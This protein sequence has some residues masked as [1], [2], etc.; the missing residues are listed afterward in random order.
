M[1]NT[2]RSGG[3][4]GL[5]S[6]RLK[7]ASPSEP[8][9]NDVDVSALKHR[10]AERGSVPTYNESDN[11]VPDD[12]VSFER[13]GYEVPKRAPKKEKSRFR[14]GKHSDDTKPAQSSADI[15][16]EFEDAAV[17]DET[18][19]TESLQSARRKERRDAA[20]ARTQKVVTVITIA[21]CLY[22]AF[23][24][25]GLAQTN[26]VYDDAGNV[27]PEV[28]SVDD[29]NT[30]AQYKALSD[31]YLRVRILYEHVL[32]VD[33]HLTQDSEKATLIA[34]E[35]TDLLDEVSKL[36]TDI[37]AS[38]LDTAYNTILSQMYNLVYTHI[39]VYLQNMA[40]AL[41]N[42]NGEQANQ[43]LQGR[44]VIE[45]E[46]TT[47]TANMAMLCN[48]TNGARNGEIYQWSPDGYMESLA[49]EGN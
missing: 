43:A 1:R 23:L 36:A 31:Y 27:V 22:I 46:F 12:D 33:Y 4:S 7:N 11:A 19:N 39:A 48:A 3:G 18:L 47:L 25:Y 8:P 49:K 6:S 37:S 29:L 21:L 34:M 41:T 40:G 16:D 17:L 13:M 28:L 2:N 9:A 38:E 10:A 5:L 42:N 26:Y 44:A 30:L 24:I 15:E 45:S 20:K 35:Y 32:D 14:A